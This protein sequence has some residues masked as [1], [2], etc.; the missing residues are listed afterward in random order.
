MR[1]R[2][3][4]KRCNR[5]STEKD[6]EELKKLMVAK[7]IILLDDQQYARFHIMIQ[8]MLK[9]GYIK[10]FHGIDGARNTFQITD[11]FGLYLEDQKRKR[12]QH[13]WQKSWSGIKPSVAWIF[14]IAGTVIAA[15]ILYY[16]FKIPN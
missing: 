16:V 11:K 3:E 7:R 15:L 9:G 14:G 2:P 1:L 12:Y 13:F 6:F 5:L 10:E 8:D 4:R